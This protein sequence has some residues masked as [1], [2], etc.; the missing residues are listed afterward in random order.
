[1]LEKV[2]AIFGVVVGVVTAIF[3]FLIKKK[4]DDG[5]RAEVSLE[6][7]KLKS[8]VV[9]EQKKIADRIMVNDSLSDV[10]NRANKR[11]E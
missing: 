3:F 6:R 11:T 4:I 5:E 9:D 2:K 8:E 7:L 10:I 1:M